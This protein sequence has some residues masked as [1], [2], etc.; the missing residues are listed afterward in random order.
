MSSNGNNISEKNVAELKKEIDELKMQLEEQKKIKA[1]EVRQAYLDVEEYF[2]TVSH[3]LKAPLVEID[4][5]AKFIEED[6]ADG[7]LPDSIHD[8]RVIRQTCSKTIEMIQQFMNYSKADKKILNRKVVKMKPLV[9]DCFSKLAKTIA[10]RHISLEVSELP[11]IIGDPFLIRQIF[12]NILSNCVKFTKNIPDGNIKV[13]HYEEVSTI[14]YCF[15]DNGAGFDMRSSPEVFDIFERAHNESDFEGYGIGLATVKRILERFD[16]GVEIFGMAHKGCVVTLKF[17]KNMV[18]PSD[19]AHGVN[20]KQDDKIIIGVIGTL[21]G[22]YA[23]I[24]PCRKLAYELAVEEINSN[25]GIAGKQI[26]LIYRDFQSDA[27]LCAEIAWELIEI[28]KANAIMG[29]TLS[30]AREEI[31]KVAGKTKTLYFFDALYEGGVADRYTFCVSA[32][33]EQNLYPML[34]YLIEK[35][36]KRCY[37]I[38]ADY[39]YGILT[40]ESSK[41]YID[42]LGGEVVAVE[43]FQATKSNFD[44]T[45][46]NINDAKP[47]IILSYCVSNHQN[48]FYKQ[49]HDKGLLDI[50]VVS[51][52][53]VGLSHLHKIHDPPTMKNTYFMSSYI[54]ELDTPA[55]KAFSKKIRSKYSENVVPYIEF[56]AESAYTSIY[57]Y[58]NAVELAGT[59]ETEKVIQALESGNVHFDGPGGKVTV[60]GEDHHMIRDLKL[61]KVNHEHK[62]ETV[63]EHPK[64]YSNYIEQMLEQE[65]G[66]KG[67]LSKCGLNTPNIQYNLM[68]HKLL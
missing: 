56:D 64:L 37:I 1:K 21:T 39:N 51:T 30:S 11:D 46:D 60:R 65:T 53:G 25:G 48:H 66:I 28:E 19:H 27:S 58:K 3:E 57:L 43:Y 55:A 42:K 33:P 7:L 31:R 59:T 23:K 67:G 13:Y 14:N 22:D 17:P 29:G 4:L 49:W 68:F 52:I 34:K 8:L 38:T 9:E 47:D 12:H 6:N 26:A 15:E 61:F 2:Y 5:Y 44:V 35:Y 63:S 16:G 10:D 20:N 32:V 54:E 40:A 62:I 45:I 41:Y 24:S 50:P 36:G 18:I